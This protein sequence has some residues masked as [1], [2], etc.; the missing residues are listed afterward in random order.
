MEYLI[1]FHTQ[2]DAV[3]ARKKI[4]ELNGICN[5]APVPRELSSSC[6]TCAKVSS[7]DFDSIKEL[8]FDKIF[9]VKNGKY[10][11]EVENE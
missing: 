6:G 4:K 7:I 11:I 9:S 8:E 10:S 1:T 3:M 5:L 2:L